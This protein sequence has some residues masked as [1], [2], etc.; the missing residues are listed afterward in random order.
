M[1]KPKHRTCKRITYERRPYKKGH[2]RELKF[3]F[4][5]IS[6]SSLD[7]APYMAV[8]YEV[9]LWAVDGFKEAKKENTSRG[10][11]KHEARQE[12][13]LRKGR[14]KERSSLVRVLR[15]VATYTITTIFLLSALPRD[16]R[17]YAIFLPCFSNGT[18]QHLPVPGLIRLKSTQSP[19]QHPAHI[20]VQSASGQLAGKSRWSVNTC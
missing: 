4:N 5:G 16:D 18:E 9:G 15:L 12:G 8:I 6:M 14:A 13:K 19:A 17:H 10:M 2:Q 11:E 7:M 3:T 1:N 20:N